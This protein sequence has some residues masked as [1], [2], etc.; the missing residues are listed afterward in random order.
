MSFSIADMPVVDDLNVPYDP[1]TYQDQA[2]PAPPK[3]GNYRFQVVKAE[4]RVK[5]G[6]IVMADGKYPTL[7]LQQ[8]KIVEPSE[9]ERAFGA[10]TDVRYK[11]FPRKMPNGASQVASDLWDLIRSY[12][13]TAPINDFI[14]AQEL[15]QGFIA[16]NGT[17]LGQLGWTGY[18]KAYVDGEFAK[19]GG[20]QNASK[21]VS[22][23]IYN[24][25]RKGT[26]DFTVNGQLQSSIIGPSGETIEAQPKITRFFPS[27]V[28]FGKGKDAKGRNR[29]ELGAFAQKKSV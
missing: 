25:A 3:P 9:S 23:A 1:E 19:I 2:N 17:F 15:L 11:P 6:Q 21:E 22:Q 16:Q 18:D 7:V 12:D 13:E 24:T 4:P 28:E 27:G 26:K 14:H 5:D 10:F 8:V 29:I 20:R